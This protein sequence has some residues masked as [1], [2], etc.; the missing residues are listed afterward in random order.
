MAVVVP[1]MPFVPENT[2]KAYSQ[3]INVIGLLGVN[4]HDTR[5]YANLP[6]AAYDA[7]GELLAKGTLN[8]DGQTLPIYTDKPEN[9]TVYF[10][11]GEWIKQADASYV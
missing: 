8:N 9:I 4:A 3:S 6:Y 10:G 5:P 11:D 7:R 1:T 2:P